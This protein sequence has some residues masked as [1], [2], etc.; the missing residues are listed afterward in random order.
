M[1]KIPRSLYDNYQLRPSH[2]LHF[3]WPVKKEAIRNL[4]RRCQKV[5][6]I[7]QKRYQVATVRRVALKFYSEITTFRL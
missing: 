4:S 7:N 5:F 1:K 2:L 6:N 3:Y